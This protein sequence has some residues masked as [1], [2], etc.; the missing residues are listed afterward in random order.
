MRTR[1]A[2]YLWRPYGTNLCFFCWTSTPFLH[3]NDDAFFRESVQI[4]MRSNRASI[5]PRETL[6]S[7]HHHNIS[8]KTS[9]WV[10]DAHWETAQ[11]KFQNRITRSNSDK[12][13]IRSFS[14]KSCDG[15][16]AAATEKKTSGPHS[17]RSET[18]LAQTKKTSQLVANRL[19]RI[20]SWTTDG[21]K[22]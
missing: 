17:Q 6:L 3:S 1:I 9:C 13:K 10:K 2:D 4:L 11:Q 15:L 8:F 20:N 19:I 18:T 5:F 7:I 14:D 12:K 22:G 21:I 16:P